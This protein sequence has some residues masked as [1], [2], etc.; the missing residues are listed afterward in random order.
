M[1]VVSLLGLIVLVIGGGIFIALQIFLSTRNNKVL[2][3][4]LPVLQFIFSLI[5]TF[6]Y[7]RAYGISDGY[8]WQLIVFVVT[9]VPTLLYLGI[10]LIGVNTGNR[11]D[12]TVSDQQVRPKY[13]N[14]LENHTVQDPKPDEINKMKI[15]DL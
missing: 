7:T 11:N 6:G 1:A 8:K 12:P 14:H 10:Y 5:A 9:N 13:K 15:E 2:G 4:I 3:L